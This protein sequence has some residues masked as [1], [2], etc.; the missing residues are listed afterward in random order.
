MNSIMIYSAGN[1]RVQE[2]VCVCKR[3]KIGIRGSS[4]LA[5]YKNGGRKNDKIMY[6][7]EH[8]AELMFQLVRVEHRDCKVRQKFVVA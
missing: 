8:G 7:F 4:T 6:N 1:E 5:W 3:L 2:R